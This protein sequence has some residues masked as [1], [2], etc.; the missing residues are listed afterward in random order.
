MIM[1]I[2]ITFGTLQ[3]QKILKWQQRQVYPIARIRIQPN[4]IMKMILI[5]YLEQ[6]KN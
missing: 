1:T 5:N 3:M 2:L 4:E 6:H